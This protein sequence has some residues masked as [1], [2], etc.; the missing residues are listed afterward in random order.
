MD[1]RSLVSWGFF[2]VLAISS[3]FYFNGMRKKEA[4]L[5]ELKGRLAEMEDE[6]ELSLEEQR[7]LRLQIDSQND[8]AWIEMVLMK[9]LG[10]SPEGKQKACFD[11][12]P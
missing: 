6:R 3:L 7:E 12:R 4:A 8:P 1:R 10:M 9:K 5:L 2:A 11:D